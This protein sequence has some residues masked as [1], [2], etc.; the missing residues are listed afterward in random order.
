M[1]QLNNNE[2]IVY[3]DFLEKQETGI[4]NVYVDFRQKKDL[5]LFISSSVR[6]QNSDRINTYIELCN[7]KTNKRLRPGCYYKLNISLINRIDFI[8][9][10]ESL[11][12]W[13]T[14]NCEIMKWPSSDTEE[15]L[16]S[17]EQL[18]PTELMHKNSSPN[19]F[20]MQSLPN[21]NLTLKVR[22]V[23]QANWNEILEG[24]IIKLV[25]DIGAKT[26]AK[27][28]E[29]QAV[30]NSR[31]ELLKRDK[32]I[33]IISHWDLDHF[34][35]LRYIN[36]QTIRECFSKFICVDAMKSLTSHNTYCKILAALGNKNVYC[37]Q[38]ANRTNGITMH[39]W[40][41]VGNVS[42]YY[43]EKSININY[44]G[45][46]VF[47]KG[48]QRS[49]NF[50]GDIR[51]IQAKDVYDKELQKGITTNSHVLIAPHHGGENESKHRVYS[52]PTTEVVISVGANNRYGHPSKYM[53]S[54]LQ[55]LCNNKLYRTDCNGDVKISI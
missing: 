53:L 34:H 12:L 36:S 16:Q 50:T 48:M 19:D 42:I 45:L 37:I 29:V 15:L 7:I 30:F 46:C 23:N 35:C 11:F 24:D 27:K 4:Y 33:L 39:L 14:Y 3:L 52:N 17:H 32:P 49:V 21:V 51:L 6:N 31:E 13:R 1:V 22:D 5:I 47:V 10:Q 40:E 54:Y 2:C 44:S 25:Y 20:V 38:P 41:S 28:D 8:Q 55:S 26:D 43:G 18:D 9:N